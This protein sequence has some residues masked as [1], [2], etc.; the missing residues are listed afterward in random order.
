[1]IFSNQAVATVLA[2]AL[3]L[4]L[5]AI[6]WWDAVAFG[7]VA[8]TVAMAFIAL[9]AGYNGIALGIVLVMTLV[10]VLLRFRLRRR[11]R[12]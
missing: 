5:V 10:T 6:V 9:L 11:E 2:V 12:R 1:M 8:G 7:L 4:A 3:L